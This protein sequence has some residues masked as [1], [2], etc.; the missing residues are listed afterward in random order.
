M[1][2]SSSTS[3]T[4]SSTDPCAFDELHIR[5]CTW[6]ETQRKKGR[7]EESDIAA[8]ASRL[9]CL[10]TQPRRP[11]VHRPRPDHHQRKPARSASPFLPKEEV[12]ATRPPRKADS[13]YPP[14]IIARGRC[15]CHREA[16]E[17]AETLPS[18][19]LRCQ[20]MMRL[21]RRE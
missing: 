15:P 19:E 16:K 9:T 10:L 5:T 13:R 2:S 11:Q 14:P 7:K 12:P 20:G 21:A 3:H 18:E 1:S 4:A 17:E 8:R 6:E